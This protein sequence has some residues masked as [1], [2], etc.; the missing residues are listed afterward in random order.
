M[1]ARLEYLGNLFEINSFVH[2]EEDEQSGNPYNC[3]FNISVIS[4][5]FSGFAEGC[6]YDYKEWKKFVRQLE[7]LYNFELNEVKLNEIGYGSTVTFA[8]DQ[9][10]H[11]EISGII[12][13]DAME[14][15]LT[16]CFV[17]DQTVLK[18]F[19]TQ[20]KMF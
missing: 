7:A 13:G 12:Y 2:S 10:G 15:S 3:S 17:S 5:K 11:L 16:F 18:D 1:T 6:E 9:L 8:G 14:Q 19:I 20:L 4:G